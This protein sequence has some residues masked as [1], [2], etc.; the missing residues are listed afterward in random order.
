MAA[1]LYFTL[2]GKLPPV[3]TDRVDED[4]ISWTEPGLKALPAPAPEALQK[5]MEV[6]ARKRTQSMAELEVGLL[7]EKKS[8]S[9]SSTEA[10]TA[11]EEKTQIEIGDKGKKQ[12][13][14]LRRSG[15]ACGT[16]RGFGIAQNHGWE[17][18][19]FLREMAFSV[20]IPDAFESKPM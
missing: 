3:A 4:T 5:A 8:G 1:T 7:S 2:T 19:N 6:S 11:R 17:K 15:C 9:Q 10:G 12:K 13:S 14:I 18:P 20:F 16:V